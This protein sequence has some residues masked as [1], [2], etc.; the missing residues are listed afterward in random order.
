MCKIYTHNQ[1]SRQSL[2][3]IYCK[4]TEADRGSTEAPPVTSEGICSRDTR[5]SALDIPAPTPSATRASPSLDHSY[6]ES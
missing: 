1:A 4:M 5:P 3:S 6:S 2:L